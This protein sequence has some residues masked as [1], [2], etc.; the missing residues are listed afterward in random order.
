MRS[1]PDKAESRGGPNNLAT[2][3]ARWQ[4]D[5]KADDFTALVEIVRGPLT[6]MT[7]HTLRHVGIRDPGA[8]DDVVAAVLERLYRLGAAEGARV[9]AAFD[10]GRINLQ[11]TVDPGWAFIR[12]MARS[13]AH[14]LARM[15][16]RRDRLAAGYVVSARDTL[17]DET[18]TDVTDIEALRAALA[19][20][21]SRS[22]QV[23][24]L[25]LDGKSQAVIAHVLGV[26]EG[27]VSRMRAK[28]IA[29]LQGAFAAIK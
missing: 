25:L 4:A 14:D 11:A 19:A 27:T 23:V 9:S 13:R 17:R 22:R 7:A 3:L 26:C 2:L 28:A 16:R 12:C 21:D 20:L 5:R 8:C 18:A 6:R 10:P 1:I 24:E 29:R 15:L